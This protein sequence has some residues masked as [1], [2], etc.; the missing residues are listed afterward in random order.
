MLEQYYKAF[1]AYDIRGV[2]GTEIDTTFCYVL[3]KAMGNYLLQRHHS[4]SF[5]LACDVRDQNPELIS[6][7][8]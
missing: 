4:P 8:L 1:K 2:Y 6:H 3:G 7:F 5:L